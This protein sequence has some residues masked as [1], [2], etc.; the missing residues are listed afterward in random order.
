MPLCSVCMATGFNFAFR[1]GMLHDFMT[2][3]RSGSYGVDV[4]SGR[5]RYGAEHVSRRECA[6]ALA[7]GASPVA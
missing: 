1:N 2:H 4:G 7:R 6:G 5:G 3:R